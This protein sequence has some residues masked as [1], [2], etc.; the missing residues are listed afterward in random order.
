MATGIFK[1]GTH[2]H[3]PRGLGPRCKWS[4]VKAWLESDRE[5]NHESE[6]SGDGIPMARGY[7]VH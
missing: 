6:K 5:N 3:S 2:Y 1:R 7:T 4:A